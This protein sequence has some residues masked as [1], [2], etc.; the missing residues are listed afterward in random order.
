MINMCDNDKLLIKVFQ[1]M[2][3]AELQDIYIENMDKVKL[4]NLWEIIAKTRYRDEFE[5]D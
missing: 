5:N 2:T 1:K 3:L 4:S